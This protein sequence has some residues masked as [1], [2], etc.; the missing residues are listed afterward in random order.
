MMCSSMTDSVSL[1]TGE[2][3]LTEKLRAPPTARFVR[4]PPCARGDWLLPLLPVVREN[5]GEAAD[6]GL[7]GWL[8]IL[9]SAL[10]GGADGLLKLGVVLALPFVAFKVPFGAGVVYTVGARQSSVYLTHKHDIGSVG[11]TGADAGQTYLPERGR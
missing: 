2:S 1:M 8:G 11:A 9:G 3:E 6:T 4:S 7:D 5:E 10:V